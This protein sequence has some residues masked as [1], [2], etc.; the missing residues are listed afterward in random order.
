MQKKLNKKISIAIEND[1]KS[2]KNFYNALTNNAN[3]IF[4]AASQITK[5]LISMAKNS[6]Y[7]KDKVFFNMYDNL[8]KENK[9]IE[10]LLEKPSFTMQVIEKKNDTD[11]STLYSFDS[12]FQLIQA[13]IAY[14]SFL[15]N[16]A[17]DPKFCLLFVNLIYIRNMYLSNENLKPLS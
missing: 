4:Y 3:S 14:I 13:E 2:I 15:T 6:I 7:E 8:V 5:N 12:P 11:R 17:V 9:K 1:Q 16:S 10:L